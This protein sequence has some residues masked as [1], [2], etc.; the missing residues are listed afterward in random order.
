M[1][2][3]IFMG[4]SHTWRLP[5]MYWNQQT[6]DYY[7]G[8]FKLEKSKYQNLKLALSFWVWQKKTPVKNHSKMLELYLTEGLSL[9]V[10]LW[11]VVEG[12]STS[13]EDVDAVVSTAVIHARR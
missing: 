4:G 7:A 1:L 10:L 8:H 13:K 5:F 12:R 11:E 3:P 9:Q 2:G 6:A